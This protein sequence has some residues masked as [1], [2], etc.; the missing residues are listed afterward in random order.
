MTDDLRTRRDNIV[1]SA[2]PH[3]AFDGWTMAALEQGASD[4][5]Y[6]DQMARRAFTDGVPQA[7][8]HFADWSDRRMVD[9]LEPLALENMKIRER[10]HSCVKVRIELNAPHKEAIRRLLSYLA[11]PT[12]AALASR[13]AWRSCSV[14]WYAAGD[15]SA[16]WN[17]YSKRG[18]LVGVYTATILHWLNDDGD[19]SGDYP[20]TWAFLDRRISDV[21]R[22]F[23]FPRKVKAFMSSLPGLKLRNCIPRNSSH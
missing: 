12:N 11:L 16:D 17:H 18:L 23:G 15:R 1:E 6:K 21:L 13:I 22:T 10:I 3:I 7:I 19:E 8:D 9:A 5:G 20:A 14:M 4:A 2:L